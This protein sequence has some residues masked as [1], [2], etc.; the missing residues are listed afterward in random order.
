MSAE[1]R[2]AQR[3]EWAEEKRRGFDACEDWDCGCWESHA[4]HIDEGKFNP[5]HC[6]SCD[7][8]MCPMCKGTAYITKEDEC[9]KCEA[10]GAIHKRV[11]EPPEPDCDDLD[12]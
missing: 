2:W 8:E 9:P 6:D 1:E 4:W 5:A 7:Y 12:D 3:L 10:S 11:A